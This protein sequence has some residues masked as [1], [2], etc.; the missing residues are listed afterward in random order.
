MYSAKKSTLCWMSI[1]AVVTAL[2]LVTVAGPAVG[3]QGQDAVYNS[4][5][6]VTNSGSMNFR[7]L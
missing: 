3:Q 6:Q 2:V 1:R 7:V 4:S 5:A